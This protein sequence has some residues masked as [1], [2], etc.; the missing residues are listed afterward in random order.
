MDNIKF[1]SIRN[2]PR[3]TCAKCDKVFKSRSKLSK[4]YDNKHGIRGFLTGTRN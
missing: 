3:Y 4:H 2:L 1:I